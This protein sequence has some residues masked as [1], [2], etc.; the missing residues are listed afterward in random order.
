M[1]MRNDQLKLDLDVKE[2][3]MMGLIADE[4]LFKYRYDRMKPTHTPQYK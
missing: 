1:K 3:V 4:N 2:S